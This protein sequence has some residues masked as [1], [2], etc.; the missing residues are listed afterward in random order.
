MYTVCTH[1]VLTS[2]APLMCTFEVY[3]RNTDYQYLPVPT[4]EVT[5][6]KTKLRIIR[7]GSRD[8]LETF[9]AT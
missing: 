4:A 5:A 3:G 9:Y 1:M 7:C 6:A 8:V 2:G